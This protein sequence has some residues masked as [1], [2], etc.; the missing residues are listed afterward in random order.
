MGP[1]ILMLV[2]FFPLLHFYVYQLCFVGYRLPATPVPSTGYTRCT[3]GGI[4]IS[5]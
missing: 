4:V 3:S 5:G 1:P 2:V